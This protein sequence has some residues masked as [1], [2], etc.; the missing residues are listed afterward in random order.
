M[1]TIVELGQKVKAKYP[2]TYDDLADDELGRKVK[3]KYPGSYDDFT[4]VAAIPGTEQTGL[5]AAGKKIQIDPQENKSILQ[6]GAEGGYEAK[7]GMPPPEDLGSGGV[8][9]ILNAA[10]VGPGIAI[11]PIG[12]G[13]STAVGAASGTAIRAAAKHYGAPEPVADLLGAIVGLG[14]GVIT[15]GKT[16]LLQN[17]AMQAKDNP[18]VRRALLEVWKNRGLSGW[19]KLEEAINPTPAM[20]EPFRPN[21]AIASKTKF[22][23]AAPEE[24]SPPGKIIPRK[25]FTPP[26]ETPAPAGEGTAVK[27]GGLGS[28]PDEPMVGKILP[29]GKFTPKVEPETTPFPKGRGTGTKYGGVREPDYSPPRPGT[30]K[31]SRYGG[32]GGG[33]GA[34]EAEAEATATGDK[35][36]TTTGGSTQAQPE[37]S[38]YSRETAKRIEAQSLAKH[39]AAVSFYKDKGKGLGLPEDV[40]KWSAEDFKKF[41]KARGVKF[42][43]PWS[44]LGR[45]RFLN[46]VSGL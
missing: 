21:P 9:T 1:P 2:G 17:A 29:R 37:L 28:R 33:G 45:S 35:G 22:G 10:V 15:S 38:E 19:S 16:S 6:S 31:G 46:T 11:N 40:G 34:S 20:A 7:Y 42:P 14:A 18:G 27:Y 8:G 13:I 4:D 36:S 25:G 43:K 23:G 41:D 5:P 44:E 30:G 24:Y 39:D 26:V 32:G 12:A 3:A